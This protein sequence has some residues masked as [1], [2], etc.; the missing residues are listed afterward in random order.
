MKILIAYKNGTSDEFDESQIDCHEL[1]VKGNAGQLIEAWKT[2]A[3]GVYCIDNYNA[4]LLDEIIS[5]RV[6]NK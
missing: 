3:G 1:T 5:I 6:M 2:K 4:V